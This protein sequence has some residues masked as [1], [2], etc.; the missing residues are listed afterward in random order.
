MPPDR[1]RLSLSIVLPCY[2][3]E[4]NVAAAAS[5]AVRA[6]RKVAGDLEV[7]VV[8]DGSV[9]RTFEIAS[10][11][12]LR[13][14]EIRVVRHAQNLGY[15]GALGRGF[16][17]ATKRWVFYTD[18]DGQFDVEQLPQLVAELQRF[19]IVSGYRLGRKDPW[20]RRAAGRG[21]T[22]LSNAVLDL[23]LRDVNCAFKI[24]PRSLFDR[25]EIESRGALI[26][27]EILAKASR[28]GYSIGEVPVQHRPRI[29][30]RQTG[31]SPR[32]MFQA[33]LEL[34]NLL[35]RKSSLRTL[36]RASEA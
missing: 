29:H 16:R 25:I 5:A 26:D 10:E 24:Y 30:G 1:N 20:F 12:A 34:A 31:G 6:G 15:G 22:A 2:N 21:W 7:I 33:L 32:V 36:P 8:D 23:S 27:A 17:E 9:D 35:G 18:G 4:G 28:L 13:F 11:L 14:S 19:D 3:E